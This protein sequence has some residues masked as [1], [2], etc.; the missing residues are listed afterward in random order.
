MTLPKFITTLTVRASLAVLVLGTASY[1]A[2]T[3]S[4]DGPSFLGLAFV[5]ANF[6]FKGEDKK[7]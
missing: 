4:I 1:L 5:V 2:V 6:F 3:G 7:D